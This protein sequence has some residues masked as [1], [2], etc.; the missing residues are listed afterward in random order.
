VDT[1]PIVTKAFGKE[2][3]VPGK[4]AIIRQPTP[5][6]PEPRVF[7]YASEDYEVIQ[8][9]EL[10]EM[11][12]GLSAEWPLETVGALGYGEKV[13][14]TLDAG[15]DEVKGE[16][17]RKFLLLTDEKTGGGSLKVAFT[18][19]RVV[20]Q[21][22]L[23]MGLASATFTAAVTHGKG[24]KA[25]TEFRIQL[26]AQAKKAEQESMEV[27]RRM[28]DTKIVLAQAED[29]IAAAFE[30]PAQP[31]NVALYNELSAQVGQDL[32][33]PQDQMTRL[34]KAS[35]LYDY[36]RGRIDAFRSGA[37]ELYTKFN[38]E[39]PDVAG[40]AWAAYNA[41]VECSDYRKGGK[42]IEESVV[43]GDRSKEKRRAFAAAAGLLV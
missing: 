18:P 9:T 28:A 5:D 14:I 8:N 16:S 39:F 40:T 20:C 43:F 27:L 15:H 7:G 12:T 25:D 1:A 3:T 32:Q 42:N 38:D 19:V 13:F 17:V 34:L 26:M 37:M 11:L 30:Y 33:L 29:I 23:T 35:E 24:A 36:Y 41:A 21:N 4:V 10:A 2:F 31:K 22:T 6:D